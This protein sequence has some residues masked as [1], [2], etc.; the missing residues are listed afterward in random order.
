M[1]IHN[2]NSESHLEKIT[3]FPFD[4]YAV[5]FQWGIQLHLVSYQSINK[6][7]KIVLYPG[8]DGEHDSGHVAYYGTVIRVGDEL[9]MWYLGQ[10]A[11]DIQRQD[12]ISIQR[13]CFATSK[14]GYH[15]NKPNLGLVK[16]RG[17]A[18]NNLIDLGQGSF[19]IATCIVFY[20]PDET[21]VNHRFKMAFTSRK[22]RGKVGVAYS[23]DGLAW[24]ESPNN[25]VG[26]WLEMGGGTKHN[27]LY[28]L[29]G[30][31]GKHIPEAGRQFATYVSYDFENWSA[32]SSLSLQRTNIAPRP[33]V[34]GGNA[35]EQIHL[36]AGLWN[37]GNV[38]LAFYGMWNGHPSNDRRMTMMDIGLAVSH[39]ALHYR[40]PIPNF[41]IV[42]AA[43][44]SWLST[45]YGHQ[46]GKFPALMQG[47]GFENV[48]D[49]TLFWY[50]P[51]PEQAS[52]GIRVAV[53]ERD[54]LGYFQAYLGATLA[55]DDT[56]N[57]HFVSAPIDLQGK[58]VQI[59]VNIDGLSEYSY[60]HVHILDEQFNP[61]PEYSGDACLPI[62]KSGFEQPVRWHDNMFITYV[63]NPIRIQVDFVGIR[64]EDI[65]LYALYVEE[66]IEEE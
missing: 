55:N 45:E 17:S 23:A 59:T 53:W 43:E 62:T 19:H 52:D 49:E 33:R 44:D 56:Q 65:K 18:N 48:G 4:D 24:I 36:G 54:R 47:Q 7:P 28:H 66:C 38:I 1:R 21:D 42:S 35:G 11:D 10:E 2:G 37:R 13:V 15:W 58:S 63:E 20:E 25:P 12:G 5:P 22:Y 41:P 57:P 51:W 8:K 46:L 32:A 6:K 9:W 50:T 30:Q 14:D 27:G 40:E 64:P 16:Y 60:I 3:L 29:A 61:L 31:G 34:F 26:S 39:D